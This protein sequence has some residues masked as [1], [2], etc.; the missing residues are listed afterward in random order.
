MEDW[1]KRPKK[2]A[3]NSRI[4]ES[5][6]TDRSRVLGSNENIYL[7]SWKGMGPKVYSFQKHKW[8][9]V[10]WHMLYNNLKGL[11]VYVK[12][13]LPG[14]PSPPLRGKLVLSESKELLKMA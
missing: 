5:L 8:F 3:D 13:F 9:V 10:K 14:D 6:L 11:L 1:E 4:K 7:H 12:A 2:E